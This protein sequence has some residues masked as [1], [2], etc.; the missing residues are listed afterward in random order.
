MKKLLF[1]IA[2]CGFVLSS[3]GNK[4]KKEASSEK[5]CCPHS[6]TEVVAEKKEEC[7]GCTHGTKTEATAETK[8]KECSGECDHHKAEAKSDC[9]KEC[10]K[11][12]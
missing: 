10:S 3:C 9:K 6:K 2:I 5:S 8:E 1:A 7:T 12:S 4:T 11:E